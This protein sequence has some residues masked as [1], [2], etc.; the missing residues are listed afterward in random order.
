MIKV[1][2]N[3]RVRAFV[4]IG[5]VITAMTLFFL[6]IFIRQQNQILSDTI[7]AEHQN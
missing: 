3:P 1:K 6:F 4:T 5:L 7:L 2:V